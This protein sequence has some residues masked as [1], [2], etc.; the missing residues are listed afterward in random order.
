MSWIIEGYEEYRGRVA[1]NG[2]C[3]RLLQE[4]GMPH[5]SQWKAGEKVRGSGCEPG[6][7]IATFGSS[8]HYENRVD[9]SSHAA[10]FLAEEPDGLRVFDQW[11]GH[12]AQERVIRFRG[13]IGR[14]V[15]DGDAFCVIE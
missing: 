9:G 4:C 7:A 13:G 6:T 10:I 12:V 2:Q 5:T 15:N 8:G 3:V 14:R 1:A 11:S